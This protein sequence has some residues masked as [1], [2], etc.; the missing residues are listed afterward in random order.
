MTPAVRQQIL[1]SGVG[2]QGVLFVTRLLA[3]AAILR[4]LAVFTSETHGMAQR[5][6]TVVSHLKIGDFHSPLIRAGQADGLLVLKAEN[7]ARHALFLKPGGW[8]VVNSGGQAT[9]DVSGTVSALDADRLVREGGN[10]KSLNLVVLGFALAVAERMK[11]NPDRLFC[12]LADIEAAV[13]S[14]FKNKQQQAVAFLK[15]IRSGYDAV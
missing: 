11:K 12:S 9:F 4:G 7:V 8:V 2:G 5:G 6:G 15:A 10:P 13:A 14:G 1:I 3:E